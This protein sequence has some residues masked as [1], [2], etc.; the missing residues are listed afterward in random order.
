MV[1][2]PAGLALQGLLRPAFIEERS[3]IQKHRSIHQSKDADV[4]TDAKATD[5]KIENVGKYNGHAHASA[6]PEDNSSWT[7][8]LEKENGLSNGTA[9][10]KLEMIKIQL[11]SAYGNQVV[12]HVFIDYLKSE[13][14]KLREKRLH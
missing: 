6:S 10:Y 8:D 7:E 5:N 4:N 13:Q 12:Y 9:F 3:V 14:R 2:P 11:I 1:P